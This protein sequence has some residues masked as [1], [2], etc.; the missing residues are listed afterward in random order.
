MAAPSPWLEIGFRNLGRNRK[1]T[2]I[3]ALGLG[4]GYFA[5]VFIVGCEE[6]IMPHKRVDAP[7]ISDAIAGDVEEERRL[8]YVGITRARARPLAETVNSGIQPF[9]KVLWLGQKP[10]H[11]WALRWALVRAGRI[12]SCCCCLCLFGVGRWCLTHGM[13]SSFNAGC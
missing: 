8:F 4:A 3:A 10:I 12:A 6:G 9:Q 11:L 7:R 13:E 1:R 2:F 5:V